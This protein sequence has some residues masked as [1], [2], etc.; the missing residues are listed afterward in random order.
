MLVKARASLREIADELGCDP[1]ASEIL[2]EVRSL[3][4]QRDLLLSDRER[5]RSERS[6]GLAAASRQ[7][8]L[9][10]LARLGCFVLDRSTPP[11]PYCGCPSCEGGHTEKT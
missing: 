9:G 1:E 11:S 3:V 8:L 4:A 10:A 7:E 2:S 6:A 5:L